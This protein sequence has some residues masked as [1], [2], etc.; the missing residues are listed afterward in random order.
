[1]KKLFCSLLFMLSILFISNTVE[2]SVVSS[3][4]IPCSQGSVSWTLD[5]AGTLTFSGTGTTDMSNY[6]DSS[7]NVG[8]WL[9]YWNQ[10]GTKPVNVTSIKVSSGS[11]ITL[12][13]GSRFFCSFW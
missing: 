11:T 1:M 7:K 3:G 5:D 12:D 9:T 6:K 2:A 13:T 10:V 4:E 8:D